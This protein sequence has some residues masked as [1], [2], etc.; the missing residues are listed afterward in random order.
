LLLL[1][2]WAWREPSVIARARAM[3]IALRAS[4]AWRAVWPAF[5]STRIVVLLVGFFGIALLGYAPNTP[6]WRV[7]ENDFLNMP[8]RWDTGWYLG[9]AERGYRWEPEH[10]SEMQNIA[11]FPAFPTITYYVSLLMGRQTLWAGVVVSLAAFLIAM[12]YLFCF[13]RDKIGEDGAAAAVMWIAAY[14]FALFFSTAYTESL[15]LLTAIAACYHFERDELLAAAGWGVLAGL[16]RPNGCLLSVVL[17][18]LAVRNVKTTPPA[19]TA[20]RLAAAATAG[21]GMLIFSAYIYQLT[22]NP[23]E[24]AN[25]HA[26]Y[27]RVYRGIGALIADRID[28][29]SINGFYNYITV[30]ALDVVNLI[31]I[32]F[33]LVAIVPVYRLIGA[34]YAVMIAMNV[35]LPVLMGGVLS[36]GRVTAVLFPLFVW[37]GV[38]IPSHAR[39]PWM[40]AFAMA[41]ALLAIAFFTWRPLV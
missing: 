22:G 26:A 12:R 8:A 11:F 16:S 37:L 1:R 36:M 5:V 15:F 31:P 23:L 2:H 35:V 39:T 3:R 27:G 14:P 17:A 21:I 4:A 20:R 40:V 29:I 41:Q 6:P 28:Y 34:P 25:N 24:W 19:I 33:A 30:L 18:M 38:A 10:A 9:I 32:L 7:Y 13:A